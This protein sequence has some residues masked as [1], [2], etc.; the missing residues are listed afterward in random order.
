MKNLFFSFEGRL[1][2]LPWWIAQIVLFVLYMLL[3]LA[4]SPL[5]GLSFDIWWNEE[6]LPPRSA[7]I[8]VII[9]LLLLR[10]ALAVDIKRIHD[11]GRSAWLLFPVYLGS[12][13]I[14]AMDSSGF[15]ALDG[16]SSLSAGKGGFS[17]LLPTSIY[18]L[19]VIY[20][21]I[22]FLYLGLVRG[23]RSE[24]KYGPDPLAPPGEH[25]R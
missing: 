8:D 19:I 11:I 4:L 10:P 13:A 2:R 23:T 9:F 17:I 15:D 22:L 5:F 7:L 18:F 21:V 12:L 16:L 24:N 20:S 1:R 25:N 6:P 14:T 3:L